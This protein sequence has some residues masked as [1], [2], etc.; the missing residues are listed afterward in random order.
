[1][2]SDSSPRRRA[3]LALIAAGTLTAVATLVLSA[4]FGSGLSGLTFPD[5]P[6]GTARAVSVPANTAVR[7]D[8]ITKDVVSASAMLAATDGQD[9]ATQASLTE[10]AAALLDDDQ[11]QLDSGLPGVPSEITAAAAEQLRPLATR[12]DAVV[13]CQQGGDTTC[14]SP[15]EATELAAMSQQAGAAVAALR[16]YGTLTVE[17][18][19]QFATDEAARVA[20]D[21]PQS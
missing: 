12:L 21:L 3:G 11:S 15:A 6:S 5:L 4:L 20:A 1:M 8:Q 9:A 17:Q 14:L 13:T 19:R 16:P 2:D 7:V 10:W 18:V